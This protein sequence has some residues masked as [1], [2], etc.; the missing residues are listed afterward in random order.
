MGFL[1]EYAFASPAFFAC[2]VVAKRRKVSDGSEEMCITYVI[3]V[4]F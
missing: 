4:C 2:L 1:F 3:Q